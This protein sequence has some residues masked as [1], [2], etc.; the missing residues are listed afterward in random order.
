MRVCARARPLLDGA[1][2]RSLGT[3]LLFITLL[4]AGCAVDL[5]GDDT[6]ATTSA[7]A[8]VAIH[9]LRGTDR[10]SVFS[11]GEARWLH[12]HDGVRWTGVY[13]GGACNGGAGWTR[14]RVSAIAHATGWHFMPIWVGQQSS[15]ICG[16]HHLTYA[17][18]HADG[19]SAA[20]RMRAYGWKAHRAIPVALDVEAATYYGS[21]SASTRYVRGWVNAVHSKGYRAYVYGS[22][23]AINHFHD[24]KVRIDGVWAASYF[25]SG[26]RSV[27]PAQLD[28]MGNRYRHRN[29][30]WQYAGD[31][32]TSG[33]GQVD[34][35]T[36]NLLLAP[37]PGGTNLRMAA[38]RD[39]P[40]A[41]GAL[42]P[43]EGLG[44]GETLATCDGGTELAMTDDGDLVLRSGAQVVWSAGTA[45]AG[46]SA[47]L[48]DNGELVV[49]DA[50]GNVV[51]TSDTAG[52]PDAHLEVRTTGLALVDD[53]A[54]D[55]WRSG[56]G[57][58]VPDHDAL[59]L[60]NDDVMAPPAP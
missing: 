31:F 58:L 53:D 21:P 30:A 56:T 10:A 16:A 1:G 23:F 35:D 43:G 45:G 15:S 13:L 25:Y 20:A 50:D 29:R 11:V 39:A 40:S 32:L 42:Q 27:K 34:A 46:D 8:T 60:S 57:V 19:L 51:Y 38:H 26:F 17:Q 22:P 41:C 36:S 28:Q 49:S 4:A 18:G 14:H 55:V 52:F 12:D 24:A 3:S 33:A 7:D 6:T 37:A 9:V 54:T 59:D 5:S 2:M 47:V 48:E 44:R